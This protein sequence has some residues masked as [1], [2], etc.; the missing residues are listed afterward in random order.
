[1]FWCNPANPLTLGCLTKQQKRQQLNAKTQRRKE[2]PSLNT[3]DSRSDFP[4]RL[5]VFALSFSFC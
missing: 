1:M 5:G 4:L 3:A 2:I